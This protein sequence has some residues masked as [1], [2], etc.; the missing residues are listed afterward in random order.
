MV[1]NT[2]L[3]VLFV[4]FGFSIISAQEFSYGFKAGLNFSKVTTED[5]EQF[6]GQDL[7]DF[8]QNSGFHLGAVLHTKF[9]DY[10][11]VSVEF[12][13]SQK[14]GRYAYDGPSYS[15]LNTFLGD[16]QTT[17]FGFRTMNLNTSNSYFDIPVAVYVR[18][19]KWL[20][21]SAGAN[22]AVLISSTASGDLVFR[23]NSQS[24]EDAFRGITLDH[25]YFSDEPGDSATDNIG[26]EIRVINGV[27]LKLP[28]TSTA[29]FDYPQGA[30][31]GLYNR[32]DAGVHAGMK[33]FINSS[34]YLGGRVNWGLR[35]ITNDNV[36]R[37]LQEKDGVDLIFRDDKD[38]NLSIQ[39]SIGFSF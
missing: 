4:L 32:F 28:K 34:L 1:K 38:T 6:D 26:S 13:F 24:E 10:F 25:R 18:P 12:L 7:E 11:G 29:Y 37:S 27:S 19:V 14:G 35:D 33:L 22:V 15:R 39:A 20:E 9:S 3:T 16:E 30:E 36:D 5:I 2:A 17:K 23:E 21:L 31:T 8:T